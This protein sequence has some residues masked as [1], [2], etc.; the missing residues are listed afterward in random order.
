MAR[1]LRASYRATS[2]CS[3]YY[4]FFEYADSSRLTLKFEVNQELRS[5]FKRAE[6]ACMFSSDQERAKT[7]YMVRIDSSGRDVGYLEK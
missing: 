1:M 6:E 7:F 3:F 5:R 4:C 2:R